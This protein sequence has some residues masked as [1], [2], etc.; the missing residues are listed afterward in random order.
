VGVVDAWTFNVV[1]PFVTICVE[2]VNGELVVL[3]TAGDNLLM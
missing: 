2:G 1:V 3:F